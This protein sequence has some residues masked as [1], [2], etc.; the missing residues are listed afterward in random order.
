[1]APSATSTAVSVNTLEKENHAR[2][3]AFAEAMHQKSA[4]ED[5]HFKAW[6]KKDKQAQQLAVDEYFKHW[7]NK[8]AE[9]ETEE[10]REVR[11]GTTS[12]TGHLK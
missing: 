3:K 7:D 1:M 6:M 8:P 5:N 4:H 9:D 10:V 2:D 12:Q 11:S